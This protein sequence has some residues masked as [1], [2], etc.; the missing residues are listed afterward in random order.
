MPFGVKNAPPIFARVMA[1]IMQGLQRNG[2]AVYLNDIIIGGKN[3]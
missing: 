1:D 2:I 3:F